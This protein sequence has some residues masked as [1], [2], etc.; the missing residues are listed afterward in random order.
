[1]DENKET[2]DPR[3]W[4]TLRSKM[5]VSRPPWLNV[6]H[7]EVELP[8]GRINPEFYVLEYPDWVNVIAI[9][10]AGEYVMEMQYRH[11]L[12]RTCVEICAGVMEDGE[13]PEE[14][15]RRELEEETGY[16]GGE[17]TELMTVSGNASTTDNLTHC[18]VARG[19]RPSGERHLDRTEDL[20]V[21]LMSESEVYGLLMRDEVKQSLMA[22]PLWR[23]FA[24]KRPSSGS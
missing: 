7:D 8:D 11:G 20:D 3:R 16:V 13:T 10:E 24:T 4:K 18:F 2:P 12:G 15:A 9:T 21:V 5:I 14:A 17:W 22:A 23:W 6:R 19:V 1:M